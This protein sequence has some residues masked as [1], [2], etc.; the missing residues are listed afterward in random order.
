MHN[1]APYSLRVNKGALLDLETEYEHA[2]K[3]RNLINYF[4]L[5]LD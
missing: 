2:Y 5:E 3:K 4:I 1:K